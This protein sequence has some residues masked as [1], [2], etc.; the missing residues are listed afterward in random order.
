[1]RA[2]FLLFCLLA[3]SVSACSDDEVSRGPFEPGQSGLLQSVAVLDVGDIL[4]SETGSGSLRRIT[5]D[6]TT[7]S[8]FFS[9]IAG[10]RG[11]AV[12][13]NGDVV[14]VE[15][16]GNLRRIAADGS[17]SSVFFMGLSLPSGVAIAANGDLIVTED[18]SPFRLWRISPDGST[19]NV[20]AAGIKSEDVEID[21]D[22]NFI[23]LQ[24]L[25]GGQILKV[26][27][28]GGVSILFS[29]L[30]SPSDLVIDG[31]GD[32]IVTE[33]ASG[34]IR[35]VAS[36]GSTASLLFS[37]LTSVE[38]IAIGANGNL[39]VTELSLGRITSVA[40][41][42][43]GSSTFFT[44]LN[45]PDHL[46]VAMAR[47][48]SI[49]IKPGSDPNSINTKSKGVVPVAILGSD[50]FDVTDVD[51]TTLAFGP[52]GAAPAHKAGGHPQ[53][54]ND[55]GFTDLVSHYRTQETG[56]A[57]GDTETCLTGELL[58]GVEFEGCDAV[59][60]VK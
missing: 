17:G 58:D 21:A 54:V 34:T 9:G 28:S 24:E 52:D 23:V 42:G 1:M 26:T 49:D 22:G 48:V 32:F 3:V 39:L 53:D 38:G 18:G 59:R 31:N 43:S 27:P 33:F 19:A 29:G 14:V 50:D 47:S 45:A 44:G 25:S 6:G 36:D 11:I 16:S 60:V 51:V 15:V 10:P 55:D 7:S 20:I 46:I 4:V 30:G 12:E 56:I 13:A 2:R 41:D 5:S 8:I 57:V 40:S 37:G 35:R